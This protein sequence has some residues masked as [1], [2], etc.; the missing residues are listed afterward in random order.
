M[1]SWLHFVICLDLKDSYIRHAFSRNFD[2]ANSLGTVRAVCPPRSGDASVW[3]PIYI[4]INLIQMYFHVIGLIIK[5]HITV[6]ADS[7]ISSANN[8]G[9]AYL[10]WT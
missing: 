3:A 6:S 7:W 10:D 2:L 4:S 8:G 1:F 9:V 5:A